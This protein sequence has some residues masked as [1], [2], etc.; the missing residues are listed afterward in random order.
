VCANVNSLTHLLIHEAMLAPGTEWADASPGWKIILASKG[1]LYWMARSE[2]RELQPGDVLVIG[3]SVNGS[4]RASQI[5]SAVLRFFYFRPEH[6]AGL[7]SLAERLSFDAFAQTPQART[8]PA[9]DPVA[10]EFAGLVANPGW[11]RGFLFRCRILHLVAMIFG[12]AVPAASRAAKSR[13]STQRR[14]EEIISGIP[15]T[16]LMQYSSE[17]LAEMCGCS[18]R[19][20]RRMFR[21][22]FRTSIRAK[23]TELRLERARQLLMET[24][25]RILTIAAESGFRHLGLFHAMFK[26]RFGM[27]P[28]EWRRR[29]ASAG[30]AMV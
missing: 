10:R 26:K 22:Q 18:L 14:F 1:Y 2:V 24:D 28:T 15:D 7:M 23:Q 20:F 27:N 9:T 5:S 19:H 21:K 11:Q 25:E 16:D 29:Y 3:P 8:F 17:K 6:V 13:V 30:G 12:D 4:L